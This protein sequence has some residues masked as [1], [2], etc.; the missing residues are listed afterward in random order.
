MFTA[1]SL[2]VYQLFPKSFAKSEKTAFTSF[3]QIRGIRKLKELA[4]E[5]PELTQTDLGY[6]AAEQ[7]GRK[8]KDGTVNGFTKGYVS[9]VVKGKYDWMLEE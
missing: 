7:L 1:R 6:L 5:H 3:L 9:K 8:L 4:E 2:I